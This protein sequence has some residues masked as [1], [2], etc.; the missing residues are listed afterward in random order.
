MHLVYL[1]RK[2][3]SSV[4]QNTIESFS[5]MASMLIQ[6]CGFLLQASIM[7]IFYCMMVCQEIIKIIMIS[8]NSLLNKHS[9]QQ[10]HSGE[11]VCGLTVSIQRDYFVLIF[12][13]T[14]SFVSCMLVFLHWIY[15]Y[16]E[17]FQLLSVYYWSISMKSHQDQ[18]HWG[19]AYS[20]SVS[21]TS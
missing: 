7:K 3:H 13:L 2:N 5:S 19:L 4:T 17:Q 18:K 1:A 12:H 10:L 6:S 9:F 11:I 21:P 16:S 15:F 14:Y 8:L 20:F